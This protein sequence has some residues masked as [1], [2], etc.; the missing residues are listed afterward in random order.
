MLMKTG[1]YFDID[2][3]TRPIWPI[4]MFYG[5]VDLIPFPAK[6]RPFQ[7]EDDIDIAWQLDPCCDQ[8]TQVEIL[9]WQ[10]TSFKV[11]EDDHDEVGDDNDDDEKD[12]DEDD[13]RELWL[14]EE[15]DVVE[16]GA[17]HPA[18]Q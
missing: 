14:V 1:I 9:V 18:H 2:C 13:L 12:D 4:K 10:S 5:C 15:E 6:H 11:H 16:A 17:G 3:F 7:G 8:E